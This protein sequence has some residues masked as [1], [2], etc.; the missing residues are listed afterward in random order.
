MTACPLPTTAA[1][2]PAAPSSSPRR[3]AR[4]RPHGNPATIP[5][6]PRPPRY[7]PTST[8]PTPRSSSKTPVRS[9]GGPYF[10]PPPQAPPRPEPSSRRPR[11]APSV[12]AAPP[13][14]FRPG[15]LALC[16]PSRRPRP[17]P[18]A[19]RSCPSASPRVPVRA[20]RP[21]ANDP[22]IAYPSATPQEI[23][24][25]HA[26]RDSALC[27]RPTR[28]WPIGCRAPSTARVS[29]RPHHAYLSPLTP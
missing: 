20:V 19:P 12:P 14:A 11:P 15:G 29:H 8:Q 4:P 13:R 26:T 6:P 7:L 1:R 18:S 17:A 27:P 5:K 28:A 25:R 2:P 10:R 16:L 24:L 23:P 22:D 3:P 9:P 21:K